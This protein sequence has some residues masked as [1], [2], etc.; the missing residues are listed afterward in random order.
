[1]IFDEIY[2]QLSK[3]NSVAI[4]THQNSDADA[5]GSSI[6]F[7]LFLEKMGK[8]VA[9]FV[10]KPIHRN[11]NFLGVDKHINQS[12]QKYFDLALCLDCPNSSRFGIYQKKF[13]NIKNSIAIDHHADFENFA[14]INYCDSTS[15][16]TCLLLYRFFRYIKAEITS[17]MALC[18]YSGMSTDTGRFC[19]SNLTPELFEAV[20][21]L[22]K[23][24]FDYLKA[25]YNLFQ[26][27]T[28]SEVELFKCGIN[29][30]NY[31]ENGKI[32]IVKIDAQDLIK[33]GTRPNDTYKII[34]FLLNIEGVDIACLLTEYDE[35]EY[36]V[37]IRTRN[38]NAQNIA[39]EFGGGGHLKASGCRIFTDGNTAFKQLKQACEKELKRE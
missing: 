27:Q 2:D 9:I 25:N 24:G 37:S 34:D 35:N 19:Y 21:V 13:Q 3:I 31:F 15:S 26:Q 20:A 30:I 29:K 4:F 33:T 12:K 36:L 14:S 16:S 18:L 5:L 10:Q 6:A 32:A 11:Y 38:K 22:Y 23:V 28:R 7:K 17:E 39:K 8:N 1:M